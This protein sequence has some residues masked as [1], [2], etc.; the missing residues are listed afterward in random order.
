MNLFNRFDEYAHDWDTARKWC[1]HQWLFAIGLAALMGAQFWLIAA[2]IFS[3]GA[4]Q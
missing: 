3:L 2:L 1:W 4:G